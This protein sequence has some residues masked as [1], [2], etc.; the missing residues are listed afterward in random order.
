MTELLGGV[1]M[2]KNNLY[3]IYG[4]TSLNQYKRLINWLYFNEIKRAVNKMI[5]NNISKS[6]T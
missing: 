2:F 4:I 1:L 5:D 6:T 3:N